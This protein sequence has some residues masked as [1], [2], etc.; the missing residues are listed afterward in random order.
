MGLRVLVL[1]I[2][3]EL[4]LWPWSLLLSYTL[5]TSVTLVKFF[6]GRL[7]ALL[8]LCSF[9]AHS[10]DSSVSLVQVSGRIRSW[11][12]PTHLSGITWQTAQEWAL[13]APCL[14][15]R[16]CYH[17]LWETLRGYLCSDREFEWL[18]SC[19]WL[20]QSKTKQYTRTIKYRVQEKWW[21]S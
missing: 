2:I 19:W 16:L 5:H 3:L 4:V 6:W 20:W 21:L 13:G 18:N 17:S 1:Q 8:F 10:P 7:H 11:R 14:A 15:L 9:L 12:W